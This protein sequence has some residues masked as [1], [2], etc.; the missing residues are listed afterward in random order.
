MMAAMKYTAQ[1]TGKKLQSVRQ[2][3]EWFSHPG[4]C[5]CRKCRRARKALARRV[6]PGCEENASHD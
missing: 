3:G 2:A 4:D 1:V 5:P 6:K